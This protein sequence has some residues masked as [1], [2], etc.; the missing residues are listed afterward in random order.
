MID[1]KPILSASVQSRSCQ[2][3]YIQYN[4]SKTES[5]DE[6]KEIIGTEKKDQ[7]ENPAIHRE[8][9]SFM[10]GVCCIEQ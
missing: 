10:T 7:E 2:A 5:W 4:R 8:H 6:K 9:C 3:F 1:W